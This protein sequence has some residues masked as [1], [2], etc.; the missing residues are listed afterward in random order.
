LNREFRPYVVLGACNPPLAY[1][2]INA[3]PA[4]LIGIMPH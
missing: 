2:A 4:I 3:V 1:S